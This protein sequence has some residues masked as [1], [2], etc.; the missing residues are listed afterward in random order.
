MEGAATT[1]IVATRLYSIEGYLRM[2]EKSVEKNE[3]KNGKIMTMARGTIPHNVIS[4]NCSG[5]IRTALKNKKKQAMVA[6]SDMKI[7]MPNTRSLKTKKN[8]FLFQTTHLQQH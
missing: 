1:Q 8:I 2:E 5:E 3:Y 7:Y 4:I 6:S